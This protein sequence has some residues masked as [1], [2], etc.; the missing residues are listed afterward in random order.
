M[1][2]KM[3]IGAMFALSLTRNSAFHVS[4]L[5]RCSRLSRP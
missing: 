1:T 4:R 2:T 5:S 3:L